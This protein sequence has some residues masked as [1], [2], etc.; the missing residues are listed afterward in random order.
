MYAQV[1]MLYGGVCALALGNSIVEADIES[2]KR[3]A[4]VIAAVLFL[5]IF[6]LFFSSFNFIF[7]VE[8]KYGK[9]AST[10]KQRRKY[11]SQLDKLYAVS[12]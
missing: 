8:K 4:I 1:G 10:D 11:P 7:W 9:Y 3:I 5:A 12:V 2:V 6:I